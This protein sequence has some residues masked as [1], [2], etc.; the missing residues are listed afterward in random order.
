MQE[1]NFSKNHANT[2][3]LEQ[4]Q[5]TIS[6]MH[7]DTLRRSTQ[8]NGK[9]AMLLHCTFEMLVQYIIMLYNYYINILTLNM[10]RHTN[11]ESEHRSRNQLS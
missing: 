9:H 11:V 6:H 3:H 8:T 4:I 2:F 7:T 1:L 10:N 5:N